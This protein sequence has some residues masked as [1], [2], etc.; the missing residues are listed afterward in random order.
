MTETSPA[1][2][3]NVLSRR[4]AGSVGQVLHGVDVWIVDPDGKPLGPDQEGEICC[5][6]PNV[7]QGYH[8]NSEATEEVITLAPDGKSKL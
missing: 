4:K 2:A 5:S 1:I 7:M 3:I 8:N 6:G